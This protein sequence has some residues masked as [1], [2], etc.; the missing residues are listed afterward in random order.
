ML[1]QL[2]QLDKDIFELLNGIGTTFWDPV[3]IFF[4]SIWVWI[5]VIGLMIY[6][7]LQPYKKSGLIALLFLILT[8]ALTDIISAQLIK[9]GFERLRPCYEPDMLDRVRLV[10]DSCGGKFGFVSSH[11]SNAFG[12]ATFSILVIRRKWL[13]AFVI[14]WALVVSYSRIYLGVHYPGDILGG[15]LFGFLIGSTTYYFYSKTLKG[16]R[17]NEED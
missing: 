4:S 15:I 6:L 9:E 17:K 2:I 14:I 1:E 13:Y 7:F 3:M 16:I 10:A 12:I 11:A 8:Y 5:P